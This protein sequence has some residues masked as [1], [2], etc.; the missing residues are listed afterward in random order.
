M[1][2]TV[3]ACIHVASADELPRLQ[4]LHEILAEFTYRDAL[5][6][7]RRWRQLRR[8]PRDRVALATLITARLW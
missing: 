6:L 5:R 3:E 1:Q 7:V 4:W 8:R 2:L